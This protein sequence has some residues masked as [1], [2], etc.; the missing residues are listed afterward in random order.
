[1]ATLQSPCGKSLFGELL[2]NALDVF[3]QFGVRLGAIREVDEA[4]ANCRERVAAENHDSVERQSS[5]NL[6]DRR[7]RHGGAQ[8]TSR[9]KR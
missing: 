6:Q 7:G 2:T 9:L 1:M 4:N 8:L 3:E 5:D